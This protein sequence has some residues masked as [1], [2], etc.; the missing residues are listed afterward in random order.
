MLDKAKAPA[1]VMQDLGEGG[2]IAS[3][4]TDD[5][6]ARRA[7]RK[8]KN[9]WYENRGR[10]LFRSGANGSTIYDTWKW[11]GGPLRRRGGR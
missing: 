6:T 11:L 1:K 2:K 9:T 7:K 3:L 5:L 8:L 4:S 10:Y